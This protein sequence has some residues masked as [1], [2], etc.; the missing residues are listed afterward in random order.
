MSEK[1]M[2]QI[3]DEVREMNEEELLEFTK[4]QAEAKA[5]LDADNKKIEARTSAL[6]KLAA[7]GLTEEEIAAL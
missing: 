3:N 4:L 1:I 6:A 5:T 2:I 7:L